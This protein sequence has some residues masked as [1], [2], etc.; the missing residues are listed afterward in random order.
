MRK[1]L[2]TLIA[3]A[4]LAIPAGVQAEHY[5]DLYVIPAAAHT[6]GVN[7]TMWMSDVAIQNFQ[8]TPLTVEIV[9]IE[10][11][12]NPD[13]I[14][15]LLTDRTSNGS[16]TI[17]AGGSVMLDDVLAGH[18]GL[19]STFGALL[20][21][22]NQ[23]FA[24]TS[25][26]YSMSPAGD[27]VGQTVRP[28]ANFLD[29]S[30]APG[31]SAAGNTAYLPGLVQN[32]NFRTNLGLVAANAGG[33]E[34]LIVRFTLRGANGVVAGSRDIV[35]PAGAVTQMQFPLRDVAAGTFDIA[36]AEV[37]IQS[38]SG[39][40]VPYAS[41]IDNRTADAVYVSGMFPQPVA[42]ASSS[43]ASP[44]IFR[45]ILERATSGRR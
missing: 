40:V 6:P 38:G 23:P 2:M 1:L 11:G 30:L 4:T 33:G 9:V 39:S 29:S 8:T 31:N 3:V 34:P 17:P 41:I 22:G 7:G 32:A 12:T 21:G 15:P 43:A 45:S 44:S 36:G 14:Y 28:A 26:A 10:S 13:S 18:R 5:A 25:R 37:R 16:V 19:A 27:T 24:V 20:I 42:S 35:I